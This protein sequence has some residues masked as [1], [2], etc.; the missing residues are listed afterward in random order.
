MNFGLKCFFLSFLQQQKKSKRKGMCKRVLI[1]KSSTFHKHKTALYTGKHVL[2][3]L[4][5]YFKLKS[6]IKN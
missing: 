5:C 2:N 6:Y 1:I 4:F 3:T